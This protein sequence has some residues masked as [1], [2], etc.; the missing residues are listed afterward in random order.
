MKKSFSNANHLGIFGNLSVARKLTVGFGAILLIL[1]LL[2]TFVE[3]KLFDQDKLQNRV[4]ELRMPT[5]MAGIRLVDGINYSLAALRG[6][7]ILGKAK[8]RQERQ[9]AWQQIDDNYDVMEKMSKNWTVAANIERLKTL[10]TILS[11][12]KRAQQKIED[13]SHSPEE[14]PAMKIL[15]TEAAPRASKIVAAITSMI[16]EEK[17]L[18]ATAERKALLSTFADSRGSFAMGLA[19]IRA[20]LISGEKKWSDDF[21]KRWQVNTAR[22]KTMEEN[23]ALLTSQ[24]L[25]Y[26]KTYTRARE[27]FAPLPLKMFEI[28]G[29]KQWN[30]ANY[31]L[32]TEA[33]PEAGKALRLLRAMVANQTQLVKVDA[34]ALQA[35]SAAIKTISIVAALIAILAGV[36]IAWTITKSITNPLANAINA[37]K[38]IA[39]GDLSGQIMVNSR[40]EIGQLLQSMKQMQDKLTQVIE[41]DIQNLVNKAQCG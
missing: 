8:F 33:A 4:I 30:M 36:F 31:L 9:E 5:S 10:R 2:V 40:D 38:R 19:S 37:V 3:F 24:Q 22:L 28:R 15:L 14:Q 12:F 17:K 16:N 25:I 32:G 7:M 35:E 20:Y 27:E 34:E 18:P 21:D 39:G 29:S 13:I 6:Y 23:A 41:G 26:F 11:K 1:V